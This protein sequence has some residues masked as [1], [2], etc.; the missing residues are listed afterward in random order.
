MKPVNGTLSGV[1]VHARM[2]VIK[3][4]AIVAVDVTLPFC[5]KVTED[6]TEFLRVN[7]GVK[8]G[9]DPSA[10]CTNAVQGLIASSFKHNLILLWSLG[11]TL[12]SHYFLKDFTFSG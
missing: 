5:V 9:N 2:V 10:K 3:L 12:F 6:R 1:Q 11:Q 7:A 4:E 8:V